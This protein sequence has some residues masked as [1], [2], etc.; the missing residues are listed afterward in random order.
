MYW[1]PH[2]DRLLTKRNNR[3]LDEPEPLSR[4][5]AFVDDELL[6][7]TVFGWVNRWATGCRGRSRR[8]NQVSPAGAVRAHRTSTSPTGC[9]SRRD[10]CGSRRWSTPCPARRHAGAGRGPGLIDQPGWRVGFPVEMRH[11]PADD[12]WLSTA[13]DRDTVYLAF[14]VN[15]QTDHTAYF[16][17]VEEVMR[18]YDGRPHWGKLHTRTAADL[19]PAYPRWEDFVAVRDRVDPDRM[20]A[21]AY[22]DRVLGPYL[23]RD[24]PAGYPVRHPR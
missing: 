22:L 7:N 19:A 20:F 2:T 11:A 13:Y 1:F 15:A 4:V 21:N 6:A 24:P 12:G 16:P 3:T 10:G 23:A 9:S 14:H 8:T 5:R 18:G 17:G